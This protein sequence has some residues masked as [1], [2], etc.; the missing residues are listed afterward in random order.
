MIDDT[1]GETNYIITQEAIDVLEREHVN[2]IGIYTMLGCE[3]DGTICPRCY[4]YR[5][6]DCRYPEGNSPIGY[7]TAGIIGQKGLQ[8]AQNLHKSGGGSYKSV[9]IYSDNVNFI[10]TSPMELNRHVCDIDDPTNDML[11]SEIMT[12]DDFAKTSDV[13][14]TGVVE[15]YNSDSKDSNDYSM[16][17]E[18]EKIIEKKINDGFSVMLKHRASVAMNDGVVKCFNYNGVM[19][20]SVYNADSDELTWFPIWNQE[21]HMRVCTGEHV[22][23]GTCLIDRPL[24]RNL[25]DLSLVTAGEQ[26]EEIQKNTAVN[27]WYTTLKAMSSG[28]NFAA[29]TFELTTKA[30]TEIGMALENNLANNIIAGRY[31]TKYKLKENNVPYKMVIPSDFHLVQSRGKVLAALAKGHFAAKAAACCTR[32]IVS[33][34]ISSIGDMV[35]GIDRKNNKYPVET[36]VITSNNVDAK[37]IAARVVSSMPTTKALKMNDSDTPRIISLEEQQDMIIIPQDETPRIISLDEQDEMGI[38]TELTGE[39]PDAEDD[40]YTHQVFVMTEETPRERRRRNKFKDRHK[41]DELDD[42]MIEMDNKN[43]HKSNKKQK[44]TSSF[45][46]TTFFDN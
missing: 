20:V 18:E 26:S 28:G 13:R 25:L 37:E 11:F 41:H 10:F 29:R 16:T 1:L 14:D 17:E 22:K 9:N 4:G 6:E 32:K 46:S 7:K 31:Y 24:I 27:I 35:A 33:D 12:D 40:E 3:S 2:S 21:M 38:S 34:P 15:Y 19:I 42:M 43:K 5:Y 45:D 36:L 8:A 30:F 44:E 39:I 23:A